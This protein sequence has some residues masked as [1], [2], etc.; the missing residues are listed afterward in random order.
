MNEEKDEE[1]ESWSIKYEELNKQQQNIQKKLR[2]DLG[3][4]RRKIT[5]YENK[6]KNL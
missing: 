5:E 2:D 6:I 3:Q 1:I 4:V